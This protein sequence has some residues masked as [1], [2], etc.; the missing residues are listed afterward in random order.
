MTFPVAAFFAALHDGHLS[1]LLSSFFGPT[2]EIDV[3][4][5]GRPNALGD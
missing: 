5:L 3:C 1:F 4:T 2:N